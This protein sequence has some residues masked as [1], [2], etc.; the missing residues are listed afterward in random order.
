M[1]NVKGVGL[2]AL[3]ALP[4]CVSTGTLPAN[5]PALG[6]VDAMGFVARDDMAFYHVATGLYCPAEL[7]GVLRT[8]LAEYRKDVDAACVYRNDQNFVTLYLYETPETLQDERD[9]AVAAAL[10]GGLGNRLEVSDAISEV[11]QSEGV[12]YNMG[13]SLMEQLQSENTGSGEIIIDPSGAT[14]SVPYLATAMKGVGIRSYVAVSRSDRLTLKVRYTVNKV[15]DDE[16][17]I[18]TE[19]KT[20]H[21]MTAETFKAIGQPDGPVLDYVSGLLLK[22]RSTQPEAD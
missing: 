21:K 10:Q 18:D 12:T 5:T 22:N 14:G 1:V 13:V 4:G 19:C 3:F 6:P 9:G 20:L 17:T 11:C 7:D 8:R 15:M 16:A 2:I